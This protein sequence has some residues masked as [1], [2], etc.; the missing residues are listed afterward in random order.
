MVGRREL[1][2][3]SL[4]Q[5][6]RDASLA[7][8]RR[9]G[10]AELSLREVA[11]IAGISPSGLY[12][13][14]EGRDGL[15]ELLI[16]D[17]FQRFGD[18]VAAGIAAAGPLFENQVVALAHSYRE[19][20]RA[21]PEQFALILGSPVAGFRPDPTGP[22]SVAVRR[23]GMPM[24]TVILDAA[25]SGQLVAVDE[26]SAAAIRLDPSLTSIPAD[27]LDIAMRSWGR[28]HGLV[29]LEAFGHLGWTGRDA[30]HL[31]TKEAES[32]AAS[33][34]SPTSRPVASRSS[35]KHRQRQA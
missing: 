8:L 2:R 32:I 22:T 7:E 10:P 23:F 13:Y 17:G 11:R 9:S 29:I 6:I 16:S 33:F 20:A 1:L 12:R 3:E 21:N 27:L 35:G 24:L 15:L 34:G 4:L 30:E 28:I 18:S 5:S 19:W 31:L 14:V 25:S 26:S